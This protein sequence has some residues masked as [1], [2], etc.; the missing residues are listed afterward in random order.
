MTKIFL[1]ALISLS[2]FSCNDDNNTETTL[3]GKEVSSSDTKV[4]N[5]IEIETSGGLKVSQAY[6]TYGDTE[7]LV[8]AGNQTTIDRP[9]KLV[10]LIAEGWEEEGGEIAIGASERI[11][12]NTGENVLTTGD[13]FEQYESMPAAYGNKVNL[14]AT[15]TEMQKEY[16]HF[17]VSFRVWDKKGNGE[18]TGSYK[19]YVK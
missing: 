7:S 6:L 15:I 5:E 2:L 14:S 9:I 18:I 13:L 12:T 11:D 17:V 16:D 3:E 19:L 4:L 8:P 10:M 1:A